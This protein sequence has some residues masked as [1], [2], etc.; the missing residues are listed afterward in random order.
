MQAMYD[1]Y[2]SRGFVPIAINLWQSMAVVKGYAQQYTY[3]FLLDAN[4]QAWNLYNISNSIPTNYVI[5]TAGVVI[6]G[7][8][9][10]SEIQLRG[11]IESG[12][13]PLGVEEGAV[14]VAQIDG[15]YPNPTPGPTNVRFTLPRAANVRLKVY[16]S[17]GQVVRDLYNGHAEAGATD[18]R[19][20]LTDDGGREVANGMYFIEL[21]TEGTST[22][23]KVTVLN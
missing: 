17:S 11:W 19:W 2:G 14:T 10:F 13:P 3:P 12:L 15:A 8:T 6:G 1:E 5:D 18:I 4:R 16:S 21:V 7:R 22:R 23:T 20:N 9:G